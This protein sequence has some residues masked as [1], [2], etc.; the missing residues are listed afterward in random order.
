MAVTE[1]VFRMGDTPFVNMVRRAHKYAFLEPGD[2]GQQWKG[3]AAASFV[4]AGITS[5]RA[6]PTSSVGYWYPVIAILFSV[7][8]ESFSV[9]MQAPPKRRYPSG[10]NFCLK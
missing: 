5:S 8:N 6:L 10:A 7:L 2:T 4:C 3:E 1:R 9:L